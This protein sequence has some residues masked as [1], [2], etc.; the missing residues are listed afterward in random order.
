VSTV[1][2][3]I[4]NGGKPVVF[5]ESLG[6]FRHA[7]S[8]PVARST[9]PPLCQKPKL[10]RSCDETRWTKSSIPSRYAATAAN[11]A[12]VLIGVAMALLD[13]QIAAQASH[14]ENEGGFTERLYRVRQSRRRQQ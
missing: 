1:F 8:I 5:A 10:R 13:R 9:F 3:R 11:A 4:N 6:N 2:N 12:L 14:F 7:G